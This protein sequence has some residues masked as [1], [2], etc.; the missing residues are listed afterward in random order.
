MV[1]IGLG[2]K[3]R[4]GKNFVANY[5]QEY[6]IK[7]PGCKVSIYAFADELKLYC[8]EHHNEL[9]PQW[10][11]AHQTKA[12]PAFKAD[13]I[14]GCTPILQWYGTDVARKA[15]PNTWVEALDRRL[16]HDNPEIALVTDVRFP[17]E[18]EYI[19]QNGG[20]MVEVRRYKDGIQFIDAGRDPKHVSETAL[21]GY[22]GWDYVI[23]CQDG[24]LTDLKKKS[25]GVLNAIN[26]YS[27]A[28]TVKDL[29]HAYDYSNAI[30]E[31]IDSQGDGFKDLDPDGLFTPA[32]WD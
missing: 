2:Y 21:D 5:M 13:P 29:I 27:K 26:L 24:N 3:A 18:A 16:S 17:N 22:E 31:S 15:N 6:W 11:L 25:I 19:K 8:K 1:L 14:Y 23:E 10:Q 28:E 32:T 9:E 4:Q 30:M 20:F 7:D 12:H